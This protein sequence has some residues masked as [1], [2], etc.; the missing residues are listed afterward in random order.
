MK[1]LWQSASGNWAIASQ[2]N[3]YLLGGDDIYEKSTTRSLGTRVA[4]CS[5]WNKRRMTLD[6]SADDEIWNRETRL[7]GRGRKWNAIGRCQCNKW[8]IRKYLSHV[9]RN[10]QFS[11]SIRKK[12][13]K[14]KKEKRKWRARER[15]WERE[16]EREREREYNTISSRYQVGKQTSSLFQSSPDPFYIRKLGFRAWIWEGD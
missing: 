8:M 12:E 7:V 6:V 5:K 9:N 13:A 15:E 1:L 4:P 10:L 14:S 2:K 3:L 11:Q 16:R